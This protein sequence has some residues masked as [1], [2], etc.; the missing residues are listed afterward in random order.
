MGF[1]V[2]IALLSGA[3]VVAAQAEGAGGHARRHRAIS[4]CPH[5]GRPGL[6]A[7]PRPHALRV[8]AIQFEQQPA[9][10][11]TASSYARAVDCAIRSLVVPHLARGRPNLVVFDEDVGLE[12]LAIGPRGAAA[13]RLLRAGVPSCRAH[14]YAECE[15]LAALAALDSGYGRALR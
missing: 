2:A 15:T 10:I 6:A 12:T 8:F 5:V 3:G 7:H 9:A 13:R 4:G 14:P 11:S 1:A